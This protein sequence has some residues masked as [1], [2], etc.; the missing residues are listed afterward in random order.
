MAQRTKYTP[1]TFSW[2]DVTT[3]DQSAAKSFYGELFGWEAEDFPVGDGAFYSKM[4]L[5]GKASRRSHRSSGSSTKRGLHRLELVRDRG[6]RGRRGRARKEL[7]GT[8]HAPAF[9]V[10]DVGRMG[11]AHMPMPYSTIKTAAGSI[12][13]GMRPAMEGEPPNWLV[14]FGADEIEGSLAKLR[15]LGGGAMTDAI[16][17]G[18][19]RIATLR[20]LDRDFAG[21]WPI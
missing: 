17:V 13:G 6:Q 12:N 8:V 3:P 2:A 20:V 15:E 5:D 14:Y 18:V 1:G 11:V 19:G 9:D 10:M 21:T 16:D 4:R 7:G